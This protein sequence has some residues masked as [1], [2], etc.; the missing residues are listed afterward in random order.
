MKIL[1]T[2]AT[3]FLGYR[4]LEKL[5]ELID[6]E[7]VIASGRTLKASHTV[8]HEKVTYRLGDLEEVAFV[9]SITEDIDIIIHAAALS[10]PW[11]KREEF[12]RANVLTMQNLLKAAKKYD[13]QKIVF[14]S[15]PSMYFEMRDKFDIKESDPLPS[16]FIN[17][18]AET[19]RLAEI[20]LENSGIPY[21][22]L[23]PRAL[24]GRG[25][26]VIMPRLI[27]AYKEGRLKIIG[28]GKNLADLTAVSNVA[29]AICLALKANGDAMNNTYNI[30]DGNPVVLW[31]SIAKVLLLLGHE[32]PSKNVPFWLVKTIAGGMEN[33]TRLTTMKE[34]T[35]TK[36]GVGTLA[37]SLTMD[38]SKAKTLLGY[39]PKMSTDEAIHEFVNW[40]KKNEE[41]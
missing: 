25:D 37:K 3:G 24:T 23:R 19:K 31:E 1:L 29:D 13:V 32:P 22:I 10:S 28:D 26:T 4:S 5:V 34:P 38:I 39:S 40:F 7:Q 21:V 18:Y 6:I 12:E 33:W 17:A 20:E 11:G 30:S 15:T 9:E 16:K 36:Y 2:G 35:L 14:I 8:G 27:R 41:S